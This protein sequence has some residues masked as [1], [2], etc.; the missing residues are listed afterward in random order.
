MAKSH[1]KKTTPA[2]LRPNPKP[3]TP[4]RPPAAQVDRSLW[5]VGALA[6]LMGFVLYLNTLG[7]QY[8]LDDFGAITENWVVKGGHFGKIFTTEYRFGAWASPGSLYRP[9]SL[10][11]F[12]LEWQIAND[13]PALYHFMNI[14]FYGLTGWSLWI[15]WR[16]ILAG[17][18]PTMTAMAVLFFIAHPI[19]TEV[20]A[21]IK[22]R[23]EILA[24]LFSTWAMYAIWRHFERGA[25]K[26]LLAAMAAYMLALMSKESSITF[27]AIIPLTIWF[28]GN[29]SSATIAKVTGML[30]IPAILFLLIRKAVLGAQN[31]GEV[32]SILDNFIVGAQNPNERFGSA[33]MMC[34]KYLK[35]LILPHPLVSDMGYP[36]VRPVTFAHW[37]SILGLV[38]YFGM[39]IFA[40]LYFTRKHF[41]S[42]AIW[43]YL[44]GFSL[45][46]NVLLLIGTSY[47][48][49]LQYIPSLGFAL[50]LAWGITKVFKIDDPKEIWNPNGK[51]ALVW[52]VAG[53]VIGLYSLKTV[54]RNP[55][56]KDSGSLYAADMPTSP[57]CAKLNYHNSLEITKQGMDEVTE[58]MKDSVWIRKGIAAYTRTI[59]LYPEY[60]D[61]YGSR[62][63]AYFRL[64]EYDKALSDYEVALK[65]RPNDAKVLSNMGFIYF[66]R[67]NLEKSEEVY[68]KSIQYDPRFVDARRNLGAVLAMKKRFAEAIPHWEEAL[69]YEPNNSTL[70]FYIGSAYK[71][72]GQMDKAQPW[73]DR[74]EAAK[75]FDK[76][77]PR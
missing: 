20:V 48:E 2:A 55:A 51:G 15:T 77:K 8:T 22:S 13:T 59:E 60:H 76:K 39:G 50:A 63:L 7:H 66:M 61:A 14:F 9:L 25:T 31:Y 70:L 53:A 69:K 65:H 3:N 33:F 10:A 18:P 44:I 30:F 57:N 40:L 29:Q 45:F 68:R 21:N 46:S 23:D 12:S 27:L 19:H 58:E 35:V 17:F 42:Y 56:W 47:G 64:K 54:L 24:L 75:A 11:M 16:R 4:V 52:G 6:A 43:F 72:M 41:L 34:W 1:Q 67:G 49:R 38:T 71:D 62:G 36:Q 32:Y 5:I 28:F 74:S 73:F 37:E 26:W